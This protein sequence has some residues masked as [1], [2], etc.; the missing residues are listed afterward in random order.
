[1]G[2]T[3]MR[4]KEQFELSRVA[5]IDRI[6]MHVALASNRRHCAEYVLLEN[7]KNDASYPLLS[8]LAICF[9]TTS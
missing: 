5:K 6:D 9:P 7:T 4:K 8:E 2:C 1:M 3:G